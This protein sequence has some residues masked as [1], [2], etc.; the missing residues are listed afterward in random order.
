MRCRHLSLVVV[1]ITARLLLTACEQHRAAPDT[2][3]LA[4]DFKSTAQPAA[5]NGAESLAAIVETQP[6]RQGGDAADDPAIWINPKDLRSASSLAPTSE[7]AW[8][9]TISPVGSFS[10][11]RSGA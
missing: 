2:I 5:S 8:P 10:I 6:V 11:F 3:A 4:K 1:L 9:S 7:A